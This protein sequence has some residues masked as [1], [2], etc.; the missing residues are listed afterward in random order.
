MSVRDPFTSRRSYHFH[1][2]IS[3]VLGTGDVDGVVFLDI[4]EDPVPY[5]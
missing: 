2:G 5:W 4:A 1:L 3:T